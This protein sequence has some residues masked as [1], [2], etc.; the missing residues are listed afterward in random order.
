MKLKCLLLTWA[1]CSIFNQFLTGQ[2]KQNFLYTKGDRNVSTIS[3]GAVTSVQCTIVEYPEFLVLIDI[4]SIPEQESLKDSI[5]T[6]SEIPNP[7]IVFIDSVF[8]NKPIKYVLNSHSH[9]H[10]LSTVMPFIERGTMLV[11]ARENIEIYDKR[12]LFGDETS[13]GCSES[14]IQISSDTTLLADTNNPIE[15]L[16]LKKTD[17]KSIPTKTFLFFNFPSMK[18]L[19]AS[20]M[21]YLTDCNEAY[22]FQGMVYSDRLVDTDKIIKDKNLTVESTVQLHKLREVNGM[23]KPS[24]FS[25]SHLKSVLNDGWHRWEL[26]EHFQKMSVNDLTAKRD[27]LLGFLVD[28]NIYHIIL[29]HAVYSLIEKGEYQK[30]VAI[31]QLLLIYQP[32]RLNEIDTIGEAFYCNGQTAI[33]KHYNEIISKSKEDSEGLGIEVWEA[34]QLERLNRVLDTAP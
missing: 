26:S 2:E 14:I 15:V 7:L 28:N 9:G 27:S 21:V 8:S 3:M 11:T 1:L 31:A 4:P 34:N 30:A 18:L 5:D 10:S 23:L 6:T 33:A 22:G 24:V 20:C 12:G 19:A 17:Y 29:N 16:H 13:Q 32:D 25:F